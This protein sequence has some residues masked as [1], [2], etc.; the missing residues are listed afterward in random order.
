MLLDKSEIAIVFI[1]LSSIIAILNVYEIVLIVRY[2]N[3][4]AFDKLLLSLAV[5]DLVVA[6]TVISFKLADLIT[7][8]TVAWLDGTNFANIFIL[9]ISFSMS[10]LIAITADRYLAVRF[11]IKHRI[12]LTGRRVNAVIITIWSLCIVTVTTYSVI[13]FKLGVQMELSLNMASGSILLYG[14]VMIIVYINI[15]YLI[16]KRT[17]PGKNR[18]GEE[19][20]VTNWR[21]RLALVLNGPNMR[22]RGVF[23]TGAIVTISFII[24]AYPLAIDFLIK[25][26][27]MLSIVSKI[28]LLLNSLFNPL[29]YFFKRY[30]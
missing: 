22:E 19:S 24:C 13:Q 18:I 7:S 3:R 8:N 2:K 4:K 12:L 27:G 29:I 17:V 25:Q 20:K 26:S 14:V 10:N 5:S 23:L 6:L 11:P 21:R 15:F 9:S 28:L 30:L 1:T 16:C